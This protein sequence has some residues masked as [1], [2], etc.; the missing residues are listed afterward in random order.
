MLKI[1]HLTKM[2]GNKKAVDDLSL[3]ICPGEIYGFIG[4]NGAGKTTTLKSVVGILQFEFGEILIDGKSIVKNPLECKREIAYIPDNPDLYD[5]MTG[6]K[7]LNFV[8]DIY[9]INEKDRNELIHKYSD[10]F[11]ITGDLAQPIAA[12][13]HG[14]KQK[15][16]I[17]S[18]WIHSPKL[19]I[20][21]EPFVGLDPKASHLLKGMM[22]E[23][24]DNG[25]AI[26]FS[27]HVLEVAEKLCDKIAIIKGG[28][29]IRSGTVE[30]VK[31]DDSLEE[32]FLEL[33]VE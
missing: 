18:A 4:H 22:R 27:T 30:E 26:F 29:L 23:V 1:Q 17:I 10:I 31:G 5:Y 32:V 8:S 6:I 9:G 14:M 15:L 3:H 33:E 19:I 25:G 21:D 28:K 12:Y 24:C 20:M 11:E 16:A 2:Y 13:S 7:Y